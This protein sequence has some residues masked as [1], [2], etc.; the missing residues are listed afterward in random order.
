[1]KF[2]GVFAALLLLAG[3]VSAQQDEQYPVV[4]KDTSGFFVFDS[5]N[6]N[7]G[8]GE[9]SKMRSRYTGH[10]KYFGADKI[11]IT[12][13]FTGDPHFICN[14]PREFLV[15]GKTYSFDICFYHHFNG[16][17]YRKSMGFILSD[18]STILIRVSGQYQAKPEVIPVIKEN[19]H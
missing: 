2:F 6:I 11:Q 16:G 5:L 18:N 19:M 10:F 15:P 4:F 7:M 1:M 14:Y 12:K 17:K 13:A 9:A 8:L 3:R